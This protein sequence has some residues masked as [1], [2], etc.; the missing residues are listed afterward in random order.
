MDV[1]TRMSDGQPSGPAGH[2]FIVMRERVSLYGGAF[3]AGPRPEGT[4]KVRARIPY[5]AASG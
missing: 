3:E 4:F 1:E 2:G 5:Q